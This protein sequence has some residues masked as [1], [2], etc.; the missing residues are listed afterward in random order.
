MR[1]YSCLQTILQDL[2]YAFKKISITTSTTSDNNR[3]KSITQHYIQGKPT[4]YGIKTYLLIQ[5]PTK[6][7]GLPPP[8][9]YLGSLVDTFF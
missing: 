5:D 4:D 2:N 9:K 6:F 7:G 8:E 1:V 3:N